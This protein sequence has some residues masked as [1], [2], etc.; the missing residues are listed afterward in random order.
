MDARRAHIH[1]PQL[2][3]LRLNRTEREE[4]EL[5]LPLGRPDAGGETD[6]VCDHERQE[7]VPGVR[8]ENPRYH[9]FWCYLFFD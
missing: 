6:R 5:D 8:Q 7:G 3:V 4:A 1:I 2:C 9:R